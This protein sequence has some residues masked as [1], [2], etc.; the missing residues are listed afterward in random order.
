MSNS[1]DKHD[2]HLKV[3]IDPVVEKLI[4]TG[5]LDRSTHSILAIPG[6]L[7]VASIPAKIK[8]KSKRS[9]LT[10]S[11]LADPKTLIHELARRVGEY[12]YFPDPMP[13]YMVLGV[14]AAN[15]LKGVPVWVM[16]VGPSSGGKTLALDML[17]DIE[18]V[19][20]ESSVK[21]HSAFLSGSSKKDT[22]KNATGGVLRQF[23]VIHEPGCNEQPGC[24]CPSR[25]MLVV[26]DFGEILA[27]SHEPLVETVGAL[28]GIYDGKWSRSIG[29]DGGR[30]ITWRGRIGFI[31]AC[32]PKIDTHHSV[33]QELGQ[34][35]LYYRYDQ[36]D[37][38]GETQKSLGNHDREQMN[39]ELCGLV[40]DF[41][42]MIDLDWDGPDQEK[43]DLSS[44]EMNRLFAMS[45]LVVRARSRSSRD[46][47]TKE[48]DNVDQ[49]EAPSRM[50]SALGQLL[51]GLEVIG[52]S[53]PY[54][55]KVISKVA[56]DSC[57]LLSAIVLKTLGELSP[58]VK[59]GVKDLRARAGLMCSVKTVERTVEDLS[60]FG[61]AEWHEGVTRLTENAWKLYKVGW[62]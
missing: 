55:W 15:M 13:L 7:E 32:T 52:L 44:A 57:P 9:R 51:I 39:R 28:R 31:G 6:V 1:S 49:A 16:V 56:M 47:K 46:W 62:K 26:K 38:F 41:V 25:G 27:C 14:L 36:T 24:K 29:S 22:A 53:K 3:P 23:K 2:A 34:R 43:R 35:W 50:A 59:I 58:G 40:K 8:I 10:T 37:G 11:D 20:F 45:S 19:Q 12:I 30:K 48:V 21:G 61:V 60:I 17:E 18:R 5:S 33:I 54:C 4:T 42:K